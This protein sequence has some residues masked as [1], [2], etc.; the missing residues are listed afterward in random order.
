MFIDYYSEKSI[1][2]YFLQIFDKGQRAFHILTIN[3]V[4]ISPFMQICPSG[5][6]F[7]V[8]QELLFIANKISS[9]S[10]SLFLDYLCETLIFNVLPSLLNLIDLKVKAKQLVPLLAEQSVFCSLFSLYSFPMLVLYQ[11]F[12]TTFMKIQKLHSNI[13][14]FLYIFINFFSGLFISKQY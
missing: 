9:V 14:M 5:Q 11:N 8:P 2:L 4:N 10:R 3:A 1:W 12:L 6:K 7:T 13:I